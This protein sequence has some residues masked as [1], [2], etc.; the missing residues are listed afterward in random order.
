MRPIDRAQRI[1]R[2]TGYDLVPTAAVRPSRRW[3]IPR[4]SVILVFMT[5]VT[6]ILSLEH[7]DR[8][9]T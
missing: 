1:P 8:T 7:G 4:P 5:G 9:R 2:R 6:R 3:N